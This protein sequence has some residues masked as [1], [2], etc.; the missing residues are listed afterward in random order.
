VAKAPSA[1]TTIDENAVR[2]ATLLLSLSSSNFSFL[3]QRTEKEK[4]RDI[5]NWAADIEKLHRLD[6]YDWSIVEGIINWSQQDDFWKKNI[7]SGVK[8]RKQFDKLLIDAKE[9]HDNKSSRVVIAGQ[10]NGANSL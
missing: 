3:K 5:A 10:D 7:R 4:Q 2:L 1:L 8:L 6:G 9:E